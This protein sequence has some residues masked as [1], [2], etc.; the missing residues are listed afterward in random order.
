MGLFGYKNNN[1]KE[2]IS[3]QSFC[4]QIDSLFSLDKFI[5]RKEH[6]SFYDETMDIYREL[7]LMEEKSILKE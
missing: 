1:N 6:I 2:F 3:I 7:I 4:K 5:S